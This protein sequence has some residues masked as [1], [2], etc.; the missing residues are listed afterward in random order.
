MNLSRCNGAKP[1]PHFVT[2][3][4]TPHCNVF[5]MPVAKVARCSKLR[6]KL[7]LAEQSRADKLNA[8]VKGN[9]K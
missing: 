9:T 7:A 8:K 6:I 3:G 4:V 5:A 1:C 2:K